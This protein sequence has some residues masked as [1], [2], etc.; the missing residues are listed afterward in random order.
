MAAISDNKN[1]VYNWIIEVAKSCTTL[2]QSI[3]ANKLAQLFLD[4]YGDLDMY[5]DLSQGVW[6]ESS[7][8]IEKHLESNRS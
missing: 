7:K 3:H 2:K 5:F 4:R 6:R 1:D 8:A